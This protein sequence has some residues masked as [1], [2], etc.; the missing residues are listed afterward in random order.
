MTLTQSE[1]G[2]RS[3]LTRAWIWVATSP[4]VFFVA[5]TLPYLLYWMMGERAG[6]ENTPLWTDVVVALLLTLVM[7]VPCGFATRR[8]REAVWA[9]NRGGWAPVAVAAVVAVG[10]I[11]LMVTQLL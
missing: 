5:A 1:P 2:T 7:A 6:D 8:G 4:A 3:P 11:A 10:W 9:G